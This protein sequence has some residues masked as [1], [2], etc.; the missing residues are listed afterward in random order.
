MQ[1]LSDLLY[2]TGLE[3][4]SLVDQPLSSLE[5]LPVCGIEYLSISGCPITN[6]QGI[7]N[8][9]RLRE[10][11]TSGCPIRELGDLGNCLQLRRMSLIGSNISDFYGV[12]A[13]TQLAE[14]ELSN[15]GINELR[16]VMGLSSL[17][18]LA[19]YDCDLR[20][21]FFKA[22]DR[23][24]R[25]V[26]LTL[27]DCKLNATDNLEDFTGLTTL[28]LVRTGENLDWSVLAELPALTTV[29]VDESTEPVIRSALNES[30]V[31]VVLITE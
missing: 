23:E 15:C 19:F 18:D 6:L 10:I 2:F 20:G 31:N 12:K 4:L 3:K 16:P 22:F 26:T 5:S 1:S 30:T 24:S 28:R 11:S 17:T 27:V 8:L 13:L 7:G 14:V 9:P 21:S 25:I 29:S